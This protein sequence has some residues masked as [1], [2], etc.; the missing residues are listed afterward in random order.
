MFYFLPFDLREQT[1][2]V[3]HVAM[4]QHADHFLWETVLQ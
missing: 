2:S 4:I 1:G 3:R